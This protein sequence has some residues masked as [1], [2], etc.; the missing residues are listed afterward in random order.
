MFNG[1]TSKDGMVTVSLTRPVYVKSISSITITPTVT[2][3]NA[4][5]TTAR[6][7]RPVIWGVA[8]SSFS[9]RLARV[10]G[11]A[12]VTDK[13]PYAFYWNVWWDA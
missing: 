4:L 13:Q 7:F 9:I 6:V 5:Q 8:S 2:S 3:T 1:S 11:S 10:D 12:W